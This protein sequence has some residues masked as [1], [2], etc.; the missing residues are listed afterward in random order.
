MPDL[1]NYTDFELASLLKKG[2][3][4]AFAEIYRRYKSKLIGAA[5]RLLKSPELTEELVQNL[6]LKIWEQREKID[7]EQALNAYLYKIAHNLAC[8]TFRKAA[9]DKK[10]FGQL[11]LATSSSYDHIE[12]HIFA[13]ENQAALNQAIS[14]LP[15]QQ[16]KVFTLCKLEDKSYEEAGRILNIGTG[17]VN[18]HMYRANVFLKEYFA[19]KPGKPIAFSLLLYMIADSIH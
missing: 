5:L 10:L 3:E 19:G 4:R 18:N 8:D 14:L 9:R 12:K 7:P 16:Q 1:K 15:P 17:T 11:L 6:F 2:D 13:K